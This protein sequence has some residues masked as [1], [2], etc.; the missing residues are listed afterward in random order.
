L[1]CWAPG[2][3]VSAFRFDDKAT[4]DAGQLQVPRTVEIVEGLPMTVTGKILKYELS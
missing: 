2:C 1:T 3:P 4:H